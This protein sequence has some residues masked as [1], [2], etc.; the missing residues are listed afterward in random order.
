VN[1]VMDSQGDLA[2]HIMGKPI[3]LTRGIS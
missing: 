1:L 3:Y 2:L